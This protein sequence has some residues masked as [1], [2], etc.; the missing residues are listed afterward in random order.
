MN[1]IYKYL[2]PMLFEKL[3]LLNKLNGH[4]TDIGRVVQMA[5]VIVLGLQQQFPEL[6]KIIHVDQINSLL[7][8]LTGYFVTEIG[9]QHKVSKEIRGL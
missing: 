2:L 7:T 8:L 5:S 9:M 3:P 1:I 6:A 4:K